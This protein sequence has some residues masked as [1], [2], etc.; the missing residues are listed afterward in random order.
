MEDVVALGIVL[1]QILFLKQTD[2]PFAKN[3]DSIRKGCML[4]ITKIGSRFHEA[5]YNGKTVYAKTGSLNLILKSSYSHA[6]F[7]NDLKRILNFQ[8]SRL[9]L[10]HTVT[11]S[12]LRNPN[13]R[14]VTPLERY[15][16]TLGYY[17]GRIEE[18]EGEIPFFGEQLANAVKNY[19]DFYLHLS[20]DK[21]DGVLTAQG[22]T[23]KCLMETLY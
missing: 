23:W 13:H 19:Q 17:Q 20:A 2:K 5:Y 10:E 1:P 18:E 6:D 3:A 8:D 16:K 15:L 7:L 11:V 9:L 22:N 21:Q 4:Q 12:T 14:L